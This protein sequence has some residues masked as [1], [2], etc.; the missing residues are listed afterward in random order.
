MFEINSFDECVENNFN[1]HHV[2]FRHKIQME[3]DIE[4]FSQRHIEIMNEFGWRAIELCYNEAEYY[5]FLRKIFLL[6]LEDV[7]NNSLK[8]VY[9]RPLRI[10]TESY[11]TL[12]YLGIKSSDKVIFEIIEKVRKI[13]APDSLWIRMTNRILDRI[14]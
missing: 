14:D 12:V 5:S 6:Y 9:E 10:D 1:K 7:E 2:Y 13:K 4:T 3:K 8:K 11:L